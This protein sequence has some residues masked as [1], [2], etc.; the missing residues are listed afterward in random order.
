MLA[1]KN[2][3]LTIV[4]VCFGDISDNYL[5]F[6]VDLPHWKETKRERREKERDTNHAHREGTNCIEEHHPILKIE[7]CFRK[8]VGTTRNSGNRPG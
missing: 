6:L 1:L 3:V 2:P 5:L 4:L 7:K 8:R